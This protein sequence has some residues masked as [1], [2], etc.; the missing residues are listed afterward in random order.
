MKLF[1]LA[2]I[3]LLGAS[4]LTAASFAAPD[5]PPTVS[6]TSTES[7]S[8]VRLRAHL[9]IAQR[10]AT[11]D[12]LRAKLAAQVS[13]ILWLQG[14]VRDLIAKDQIA[15]NTSSAPA[16]FVD[17]PGMT[18]EPLRPGLTPLQQSAAEAISAHQVSMSADVTNIFNRT[19]EVNFA[20]QNLSKR[21]IQFYTVP[22]MYYGIGLYSD[23]HVNFVSTIPFPSSADQI[24]S[25]MA[26]AALGGHGVISGTMSLPGEPQSQQ[27]SVIAPGGTLYFRATGPI[28]GNDQVPTKF[29]FK[30]GGWDEFSLNVHLI[31][32]TDFGK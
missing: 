27:K 19:A 20:V 4:L 6:V 8:A 15:A 25:V 21:P 13:Q 3:S 32:A 14:Q 18:V 1:T 24:N 22:T 10:D 11:I 29:T 30:G 16:P 9:E 12:A 26:M 31:Q 17:A 2:S 5:T 28:N 7:V 23:L